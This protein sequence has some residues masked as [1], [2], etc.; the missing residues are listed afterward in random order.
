MQQIEIQAIIVILAIVGGLMMVM[1][2]LYQ[3]Y[4]KISELE[5]HIE[6][7]KTFLEDYR[8]IVKEQMNTIDKLQKENNT[9]K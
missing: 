4:E 5:E 6:R 9:L 1:Q 2:E 7:Q 3:S 8:S